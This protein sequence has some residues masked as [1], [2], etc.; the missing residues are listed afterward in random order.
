M[1]KISAQLGEAAQPSASALNLKT[2]EAIFR[3][4]P[5]IRSSGRTSLSHD[6]HA[7]PAT[8]SIV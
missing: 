6:A 2:V 5:N 7:S 8:Q 4:V 3:T 1:D